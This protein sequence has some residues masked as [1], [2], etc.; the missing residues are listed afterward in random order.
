MVDD[1]KMLSHKHSYTDLHTK[2]TTQTETYFN[3]GLNK[4]NE[5]KIMITQISLIHIYG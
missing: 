5:E 4:S 3:L 1:T 2:I